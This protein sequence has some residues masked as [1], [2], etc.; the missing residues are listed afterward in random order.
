MNKNRN[1]FKEMREQRKQ[2]KNLWIYRTELSTAI[3]VLEQQRQ[4]KSAIQSKR[5]KFDMQAVAFIS[6]R[7]NGFSSRKS[8]MPSTSP[9]VLT[10]V[11]TIALQ[12]ISEELGVGSEESQDGSVFT[13]LGLD[14]LLLLAILARL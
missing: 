3:D 9:K 8:E 6:S 11:W 13:D 4:L 5:A 12:I 1:I 7:G 2:V 10:D 14:S